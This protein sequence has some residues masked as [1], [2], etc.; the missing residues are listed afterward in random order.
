MYLE[1]FCASLS[2]HRS[3]A[4]CSCIVQQHRLV[5]QFEPLNLLDRPLGGFGLVKDYESLT[6]RFEVSLS[7]KFDDIAV[8]REDFGEGFFKLV[9]F[10]TFF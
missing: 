5:E 1:V 2:L 3:I 4:L 9:R 6:F 7:D 10:D 8:F